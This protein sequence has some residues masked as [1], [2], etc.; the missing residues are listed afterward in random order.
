MHSKSNIANLWSCGG[1]LAKIRHLECKGLNVGPADIHRFK[2]LQNAAP[3][4]CEVCTSK[5]NTENNGYVV[6]K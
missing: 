2:I 3:H 4:A 6:F 1:N 5:G